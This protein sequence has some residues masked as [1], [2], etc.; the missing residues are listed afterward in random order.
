MAEELVKVLVPRSRLLEVY[1][2]LGRLAT[3][4]PAEAAGEAM[5]DNEDLW[6]DAL[7]ERAYRDSSDKM[8]GLLDHLADNPGRRVRSEELAKV[9]GYTR[10]Q[11]AGVLGAFGRRWKNRYRN[12]GRWFFR[13]EWSGDERSWLWWMEPEVAEVVRSTR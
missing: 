12:S 7:V 6:D 4:S 13:A 10:P 3:G 11:L 5:S 2:L 8:K 9:I 1:A